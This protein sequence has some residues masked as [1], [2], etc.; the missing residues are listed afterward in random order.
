MRLQCVVA[1][2]QER[3]TLVRGLNNMHRMRRQLVGKVN[4]FLYVGSSKRE[5]IGHVH[6]A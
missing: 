6:N 1:Y 3:R 5:F 2:T 4:G